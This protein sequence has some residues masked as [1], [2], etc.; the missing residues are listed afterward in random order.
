MSG[1]D[2]VRDSSTRCVSK[3]CSAK[4]FS[5]KRARVMKEKFWFGLIRRRVTTSEARDFEPGIAADIED[6]AG[7]EGVAAGELVG[8]ADERVGEEAVRSGEAVLARR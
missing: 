4:S 1:S 8:L 7:A 3:R 5:S 2:G 6:V